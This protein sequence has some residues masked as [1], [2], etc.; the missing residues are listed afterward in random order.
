MLLISHRRLLG[1]FLFDKR[2]SLCRGGLAAK[3]FQLPHINI[4]FLNC[5]RQS[6]LF[7]DDYKEPK[8]ALTVAKSILDLQ[9]ALASL[10]LKGS[11]LDEEEK[12]YMKMLEEHSP[13]TSLD[14][15]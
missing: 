1:E 14:V 3:P 15:R 7:T 4:F 13:D 5:R 12:E 11:T 9:P 6:R 2:V 10:L 8:Q